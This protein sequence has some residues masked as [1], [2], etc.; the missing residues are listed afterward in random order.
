MRHAQY[1]FTNFNTQYVCNHRVS[2]LNLFLCNNTYLPI[3]IAPF[4]VVFLGPLIFW[5]I[6]Q[7]RLAAGY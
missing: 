5:D 2:G 1:T 6:M 4:K 7:H 3:S